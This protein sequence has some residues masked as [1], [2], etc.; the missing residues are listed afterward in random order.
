LRAVAIGRKREAEP[1]TAITISRE[2]GSGGMYIGRKAAQ[3]LGY[4]LAD[5][6]VIEDV[7]SEYG[8]ARFE[9]VYE[10]APG[11][12]DNFDEMRE[13]VVDFLN[14]VI[15][16][17]AQHGDVVIV[18]R[19]GFAVLAPFSD[20]L[21]VRVQAPFE[22]RVRW[23]MDKEGIAD[24]E[25]ARAFVR[26]SDR[27]RSGFV[28]FSYHVSWGSSAAFDVVVNTDK[29]DPDLAAN[30]LVEAARQL[31]ER[32]EKTGPTTDTIEVDRIIAACVSG[33]L[34]RHSREE[35]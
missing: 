19:G 14:E 25:E 30:W 35:R 10:S 22:S 33:I 26:Q 5:K 1:V 12:W 13:G 20:V 6:S 16:G 9:K 24:V 11:F 8:L 29:V 27:T 4:Q 23:L 3:M 31:E 34:A 28:E 17:L 7:F 18:G 21:H 2:V 32:R 15:L